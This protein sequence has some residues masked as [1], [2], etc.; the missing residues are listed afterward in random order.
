MP[1]RNSPVKTALS[2]HTSNYNA[3][4]LS[5]KQRFSRHLQFQ[6]SY[7][8]SKSVDDESNFNGRQRISNGRREK[9]SRG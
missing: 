2:R 7:T 5:V 3:L 1:I 8:Y 4:L 9:V 6:V